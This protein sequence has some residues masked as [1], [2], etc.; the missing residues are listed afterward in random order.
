[1]LIGTGT[2]LSL[3]AVVFLVLEWDGVLA[4]TPLW[5]RPII[6][7]FHSA[8]C[9]TA[10]FNTVD[11]AALTNAML[12]ISILLMMIGGGP[13][14]TAGGF[15]V[16]TAVVLV[17]HAWWTFR[18]YTRINLF[19]RTIP[20]ITIVRATVTAMLFAVIAVIALTTLLMLEQS[21]DPHPSSQDSFLDAVF[22][23]FSALGT[24]G[25]STGLTP[26]LTTAGKIIVVLL[27]FLGRLGP[28]TVFVALS[29]SERKKTIEH[30]A[31]ELLI[32]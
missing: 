24:V 15:K 10:G 19:R 8:T 17:V 21:S 7:L 2:L 5:Q 12:F 26:H 11:I 29:R 1:M 3:G 30:P 32:G 16:S 9:R 25:L 6:A 14:S 4:Q 27:M 20:E 13:C 22:E 23:V 31:E 28:I 18:G